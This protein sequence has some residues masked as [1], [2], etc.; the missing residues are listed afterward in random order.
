[1]IIIFQFSPALLLYIGCN[2]F[3]RWDLNFTMILEL[4][5]LLNLYFLYL[6]RIIKMLYFLYKDYNQFCSILLWTIISS[7]AL[8]CFFMYMDVDEIQ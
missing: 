4:A 1:M 7:W 8:D 2:N 3:E 6:S 5:F